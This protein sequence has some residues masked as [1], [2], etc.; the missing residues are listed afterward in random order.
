MQCHLACSEGV[1]YLGDDGLVGSGGS[2]GCEDKHK[3]EDEGI[4]GVLLV[5][6]AA[7]AAH[8]AV[9]RHIPVSAEDTHITGTIYIIHVQCRHTLL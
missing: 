6:D 5:I 1:S 3:V 2:G 4:A 7:R 9:P 8:N